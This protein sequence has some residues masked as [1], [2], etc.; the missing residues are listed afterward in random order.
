MGAVRDGVEASTTYTVT[1]W[2]NGGKA[3]F[4]WI[5]DVVV[6]TTA[7]KTNGNP[8]FSLWSNVVAS[9]GRAMLRGVDREQQNRG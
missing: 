4:L 5:G 7:S 3:W 8:G 1:V 6:P 2:R 9:L